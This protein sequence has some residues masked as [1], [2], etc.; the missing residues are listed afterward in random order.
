MTTSELKTIIAESTN[1]DAYNS[2]KVV[3]EFP[4]L[5][6]RKEITG[7]STLHEFVI[8]QIN[9]F[10]EIGE[11]KLPGLYK[12]SI[13]Y[14]DRIRTEILTLRIDKE[15]FDQN[16][17]K[18]YNQNIVSRIN[19]I[20]NNN[21]PFTYDCPETEFLKYVN[22]NYPASYDGAYNYFIGQFYNQEKRSFFGYMLAFNFNN[23]ENAD[24]RRLELDKKIISENRRF[25]EKYLNESESQMA[26]YLKN[27]KTKYD[28]H[29]I[30]LQNF[31]D[32]KEN[33]FNEWFGKSS[34]DF[35]H[36]F[37][38]SNQQFNNFTNES[39]EKIR[40]LE[41][42]YG[43]LLSLKKPAE[44]WRLRAIDLNK[45][46][47][48]SLYWLI[49]LVAFTASL[50]F[51]LLWLTPDDMLIT[52]FSEDKSKAIRW[53]IV[54]LA[55]LSVLIYGIRTLNKVTFS[56][57]HLARDAE[58]REQLT[59]V[60]L[61]LINEKSMD[62]EDRLLIMQSLFSRADTGLLKDDSSPSMPGATNIV[63]KVLR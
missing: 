52:I 27:S 41:K 60:Y 59:Y 54:F 34:E 22:Q 15:S 16:N 53:S 2:I 55:F 40:N 13:N 31:K 20:N 10:K 38:E 35:S 61:S 11:S 21:Y 42:T 63:E 36:F 19:E 48:K 18:Y 51:I 12:K 3:F 5:N 24:L 7:L 58:E 17:F 30:D 28:E 6:Y 62:K 32:N 47:W 49:S 9:G 45:Q 50:L 39:V 57:F 14:F 26:E 4:Y 33:S 29:I 56:S 43:E 37:T 1:P 23:K 8:Q 46:G 44:Y 25:F